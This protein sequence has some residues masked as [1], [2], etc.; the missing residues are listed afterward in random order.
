[1]CVSART[2]AVLVAMLAC[3]AALDTAARAEPEANSLLDRTFTCAVT[4]RGG[5]YLLDARAHSGTRLQ[6]KWAKLPYAGFRTGVFG[7][8]GGNM[9]AW[10]TSG[11]PT[12]TTTIDNEYDTFDVK[13]FGT[14][15][16]R[17]ELCREGSTKVPL[18][19]SGLRGGVA[20]QLGAEFECLT[21]KQIVVRIRAV[22]AT[23]GA[24]HRGPL[25]QTSHV[26]VREAKLVA[27]T[28]AGKVLAYADV[29]ESGRARLFTAKGCTAG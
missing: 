14:V 13:T 26:V 21:P 8:P 20:A 7:G 29:T 5:E 22:L 12:A 17:R 6:G 16:L 15:G 19:S 10:V 18:T 11:K 9:L 28:P 3:A 24:L 25:Y 4:L 27:R 23:P 1:M 2:A